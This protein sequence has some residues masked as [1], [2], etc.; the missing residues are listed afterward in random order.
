MRL[1]SSW[2]TNMLNSLQSVART[3]SL[4]YV[5]LNRDLITHPPILPGL[6]YHRISTFEWNVLVHFCFGRLQR[7]RGSQHGI[8]DSTNSRSKEFGWRLC[9]CRR[10]RLSYFAYV[11]RNPGKVLNLLPPRGSHNSFCLRVTLLTLGF[12]NHRSNGLDWYRQCCKLC[13]RPTEWRRKFLWR[14]AEYVSG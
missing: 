13:A 2:K 6:C 10:E 7:S 5:S 9:L 3:R 12:E 8:C 1:W 11:V 4:M 14:H